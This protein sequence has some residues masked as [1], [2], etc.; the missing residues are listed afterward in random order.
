MGL[1][2]PTYFAGMYRAAAFAYGVGGSGVAGLQVDMPGGVDANTS[3]QTLTL[4]FGNVTL[5]DGTVFAPLATTAKVTVGTG[6]AAD[7]VTPSAVSDNTPEIYQSANFTAATFSNSHGTGD[8]VA[9]A[10]IG[11]QEALNFASAAGGGI[12]IVDAVWYKLGGTAGILAAATVPTG[13][14]IWDDHTGSSGLYPVQSVSVPL[15]LAQIQAA[16]TTPVSIIPAPGAGNMI[17]VLSATLNLIYGSAAYSGGGAAQLSYGTALTYPA[18][19]LWAATDFTSLSANQ[20][21]TVAGAA[22]TSSSANYTNKAITY[23]NAAANFTVGT[24]GSGKLYVT[25]QVI[26]SVS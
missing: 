16:H 25:Y 14:T 7:T 3:T 15:T 13:V 24:G 4:A 5:D 21:D 18:T 11:L 2:N 12:V 26:P 9:S 8:L 23:S 10:T 17:V 22:A 1:K 19:A 20:T 6:S